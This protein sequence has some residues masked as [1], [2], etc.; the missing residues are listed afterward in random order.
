MLPV[1]IFSGAGS[2]FANAMISEKF[3]S[4]RSFA[5]I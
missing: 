5:A 1:S 2:V 3:F 4:P